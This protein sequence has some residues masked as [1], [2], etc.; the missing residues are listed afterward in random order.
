MMSTPIHGCCD[1]ES[2]KLIALLEEL[3]SDFNWG[4]SYMVLEGDNLHACLA[5]RDEEENHY[6]CGALVESIRQLARCFNYVKI[7]FVKCI[8]FEQF[9]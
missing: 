2:L 1:I 7:F 9:Y 5:V 6:M 3:K 4:Y 8:E